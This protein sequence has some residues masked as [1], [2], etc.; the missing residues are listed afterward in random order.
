MRLIRKLLCT[1]YNTEYPVPPKFFASKCAGLNVF[2]RINERA[3]LYVNTEK[4]GKKLR[5]SQTLNKIMKYSFAL[6]G[7]FNRANF[8]FL[9]HINYV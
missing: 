3:K 2:H 5:L 8:K 1:S 6:S 7:K 9:N 4:L